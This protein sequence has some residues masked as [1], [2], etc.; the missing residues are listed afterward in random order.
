MSS[1][2]STVTGYR[3]RLLAAIGETE[4]ED[5]REGDPEIEQAT[6]SYVECL[7]AAIFRV[8]PWSERPRHI[9]SE[10][11]K[12][13]EWLA[14]Q[15]VKRVVSGRFR[16]DNVRLSAGPTGRAD[17]DARLRLD[18]WDAVVERWPMSGS[19][20]ELDALGRRVLTLMCE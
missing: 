8:M 4:Y 19:K 13:T 2:I 9:W 17:I 10:Y 6:I 3:D 14:G 20:A 7:C 15:M 16:D 1:Q 5:E 11:R 12:W 18:V